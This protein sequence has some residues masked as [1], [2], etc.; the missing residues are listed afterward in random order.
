ML[1]ALTVIIAYLL[2][3][4]PTSVIIS[5][6][7]MKDDIRSHGSGNPGTTNM[8]RTFGIGHGILTFI[9]DV[10]KGVLGAFVGLWLVGDS[11]AMLVG[12]VA[13]VIGHNWSV[14]LRFKGGK[15]AAT[16]FGAII[17][18][19]PI[20]G[21]MGLGVFVLVVVLT[22]YVSMGSML[23]TTFVWILAAVNHWND[24]FTMICVTILWLMLIY[25]HRGNIQRLSN[26]TENK[27]SFKK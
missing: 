23:S 11:R 10:A 18:V 26:G 12:A 3:A 1:Y 16:S 13:V 7:I 22:K 6:D 19:F 27:L 4:I 24:I 25:R 17:A 20:W 21:L 2:G 9:G 5:K 15:G 8:I 14:F